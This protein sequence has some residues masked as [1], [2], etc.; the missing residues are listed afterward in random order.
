[1]NLFSV[2]N[3]FSWVILLLPVALILLSLACAYIPG[4]P[5]F[6]TDF[7]VNLFGEVE[8]FGNAVDMLS[9]LYDSGKLRAD[10]ILTFTLGLLVSSL[11]ETM[12]ISCCIFGVKVTFMTLNRAR[13]NTVGGIDQIFVSWRYPVFLL[14]AVGVALGVLFCGAIEDLVPAMKAILTAAVPMLI[15]V[16]GIFIM[17]RSANMFRREKQI[18]NTYGVFVGLFGEIIS[19]TAITLCAV[20]CIVCLFV[21]PEFVRNGMPVKVLL[22]LYFLGIAIIYL[23]FQ[24]TQW[25][26]PRRYNNRGVFR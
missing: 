10:N 20:L 12:I 23:T 17:L 4:A 2:A 13:A 15:V 5:E 16:Y 9:I 1:M 7:F 21:G 25:I 22:S 6:L 3:I 19:N 26:R 14:T 8:L 11:A 24:L 18:A